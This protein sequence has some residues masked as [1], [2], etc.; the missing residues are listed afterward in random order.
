MKKLALVWG[1]QRFG[2]EGVRGEDYWVPSMAGTDW[3]N[4]PCG[5]P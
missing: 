2:K 1:K 5:P 3:V 4:G